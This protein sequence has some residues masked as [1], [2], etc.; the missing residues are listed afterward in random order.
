MVRV[1]EYVTGGDCHQQNYALSFSVTGVSW[2]G[3]R[4]QMS[5]TTKDEALLNAH[6][7]HLGLYRRVAEKLG[8]N[9]SYVSR[10]ASGTRKNLKVRRA[11]LDELCRIQR[12]SR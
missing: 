12:G 9:P 7:L 8:V 3:H 1:I 2:N 5:S 4:G 10:V 11:I 6:R